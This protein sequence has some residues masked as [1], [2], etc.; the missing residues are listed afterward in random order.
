MSVRVARSGLKFSRAYGQ[1]AAE[2]SPLVSPTGD[3][4]GELHACVTYRAEMP[5]EGGVSAWGHNT[6]VID[7]SINTIQLD[8][9]IPNV[10]TPVVLAPNGQPGKGLA[11]HLS[12]RVK[13]STSADGQTMQIDQVKF[14]M[15]PTVLS[16][17]FGLISP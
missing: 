6:D 12:L 3:E 5:K 4:V 13:K 11:N 8:N 17:D 15:Q 16:I 14:E 10:L 9:Q 7:F 2:W 1:G